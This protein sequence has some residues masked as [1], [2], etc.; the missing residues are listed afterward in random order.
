M[1]EHEHDL[2][3]PPE[4]MVHRIVFDAVMHAL[5]VGAPGLAEAGRTP[6]AINAAIRA[7]AQI[8]T[9][10]ADMIRNLREPD[11]LLHPN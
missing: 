11:S 7:S 3:G 6:I 9:L 10:V 4:T 8:D 5:K 2:A 1:A